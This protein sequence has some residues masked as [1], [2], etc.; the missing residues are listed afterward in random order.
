MRSR[1]KSGRFMPSRENDRRQE[2]SG[3]MSAFNKTQKLDESCD[4]D[5][6]ENGEAGNSQSV[7]T[8]T[9][10]IYTDIQDT[11]DRKVGRRIVEVDL[12]AKHLDKGCVMCS[13]PLQLSRIVHEKSYGLASLLHIRCSECHFVNSMPTEKRHHDKNKAK[14]MP[15]FDINTKSAG[16]MYALF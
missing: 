8:Q 12:L 3:R 14:T 10:D 1:H 2:A 15:V 13:S 5:R 9:E 7:M 6:E 4:N 11:S 16:G